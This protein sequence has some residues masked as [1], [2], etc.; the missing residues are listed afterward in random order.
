MPPTQIIPAGTRFGRLVVTAD[1]LSAEP[2]VKVRCDC[3]REL[4]VRFGNLGKS[5]K[6]CGCSKKGAGN[7]RHRHG[8]AGT[9]IYNIWSEMIARCTRP[10]HA[11]YADYGGRGI[12]VCTGWRDFA[13]FYEDMGER[14][15]GR[16]LDRKDNDGGYWCGHCDECV[17]AGRPANCHWAT[18]IEQRR[19]RRPQR[20]RKRVKTEVIAA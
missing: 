5:A 3:G 18:L 16:T 20:P 2:M 8:H 14:P 19:N 13:V 9:R 7:G 1:R 6:S 4:E 17:N 11:R 12:A 10:T 15:A